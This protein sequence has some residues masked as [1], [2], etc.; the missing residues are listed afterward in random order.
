MCY[1]SINKEVSMNRWLIRTLLLAL[2]MTFLWSAGLAQKVVTI[3]TLQY[4][5]LDSL[6]KLDT[7]QSAA[8]GKNLDKTPYWHGADASSDTVSITGV[9][10]VKPSILAYTL[11]RYNIYI[12]DTTTG[13]LW[14][15]IDVITNDTLAAAQASGITALDT[16]MVVTMTGRLEEYGSQ[17]NSLLEMVHYSASTPVYTGGTIKIGTLLA[18][19]PAAKEITL[20]SLVKGT[21]PLPSR[22]EKYESM[23]V[24]VRN[25][26]VVAVDY[27]YGTF[28]VQDAA[29]NQIS[30]YDASGWYTLRGFKASGS[31]YSPPPVGTQ[32]SYLRGVIIPSSK[33]NT[34]GDYRIAPLYP[35]PNQQTGSKY[36]G[37]IGIASYAPQV[38]S[39]TR[40]PTPPKATDAV[41]VSWIAHNLNTGLHIDSSFFNWRFGSNTAVPWTRSKVTAISGDS[42]YTATIPAAGGDSLVSYY[43]EVYGGGVYG[44]SPDP[45]K[46]LFY[47]VRQSGL[48]I[49]D[50]QY[51]PYVGGISGFLGDTITVSGVI[52][53]DTTDIKQNLSGRPTLWMASSTGA[54]NGI[55]MYA[56]SA[57]SGLDTLKRGD[58]LRVTGVVSERG[59]SSSDSRTCIQVMPSST[60]PS[61]VTVFRRGVA[62]PAA[63]TVSMSGSGSLS[64]QDANRPVKGTSP[65]EQYESVLIKTPLVYINVMNADNTAG[66]GSS[67]FGEFFVSTTKGATT[68][69][70]G[71]RVNDDGTNSYYCDT[72]QAYQTAWA[73]AH[74]ISPAKTKLMP[75]GV[76]IASLTGILTFSNGEYKLEPRKNDDFGTITGI[77]YQIGDV[78]PKNFELSQNYPNPFNPTTTIRY[79]LPTS[80]SVTLKVFNILGQEVMRLVDGEQRAG[81]YAVVFDASRLSS[82]VYFYQLQTDTYSNVKKMMLLK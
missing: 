76:S 16:G 9:V 47:Q 63:T 8:A 38:S 15:G 67:N 29:G 58:S 52:T 73:T 81:A 21:T 50:V 4:V 68:L 79:S 41:K 26:T 31:K 23:Y 44:V 11:T 1:V 45:A 48:T 14:G 13:Q 72:T 80:S 20:D 75:V 12:Q 18:S 24:V 34:C 46:P 39:I 28:T 69:A 27:T 56:T 66:T 65:F 77:T 49:K 43:V 17:N 57:S 7:L 36:P 71:I 70:Y 42:S 30:T 62:V 55:A 5:P 59:V 10:M 32:L 25:V 35:G 64:Y 54:W 22:G 33:A 61:P 74:P 2:V 37:D 78:V 6:R 82:G 40:T 19:R 3:P 53:A 51:T 60:V